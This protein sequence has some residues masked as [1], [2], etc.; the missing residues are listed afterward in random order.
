V[1]EIFSVLVELVLVKLFTCRQTKDKN[2]LMQYTFDTKKLIN[3][4]EWLFIG[5]FDALEQRI[6]VSYE[7][8]RSGDIMMT[9]F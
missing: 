5:G 6:L 8:S 3:L 9:R 4:G 1:G 7:H 2:E